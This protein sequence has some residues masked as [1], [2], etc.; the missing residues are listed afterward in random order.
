[1][2]RVF[3]GVLAAVLMTACGGDGGG[4]NGG[5]EC[6]ATTDLNMVD[7]AFE[8]LCLQVSEGDT[9]NLTNEGVAVHSF[10]VESAGIDVDVPAGE[11]AT[12]ALEGVGAGTTD[13]TCTFHPEMIGTLEVG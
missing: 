10:T 3:I 7:N 12:A 11:T 13:F 9:I 6:V 4:G 1:M 8:P 2:T 5:E